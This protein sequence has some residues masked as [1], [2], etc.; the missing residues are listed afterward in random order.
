MAASEELRRYTPQGYFL[1]VAIE[2]GDTVTFDFVNR[3]RD[4]EKGH[5]FFESGVSWIARVPSGTTVT[6]EATEKPDYSVDAD[7]WDHN[8]HDSF[9]AIQGYRE[10][11]PL[12]A[13]R[14]TAAG[15]AATI[16][17]ITPYEMDWS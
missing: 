9:T 7:W 14:F 10:D 15:G 12:A 4:I 3:G 17:L 13:M 5:H 2:D 6:V 1:R 16:T 11:A 8:A